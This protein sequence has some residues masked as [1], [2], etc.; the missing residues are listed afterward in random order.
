MP[1]GRRAALPPSRRRNRVWF[2]LL[3]VVCICG[4]G[5]ALVLP[6]VLLPMFVQSRYPARKV[7][8]LSNIRQTAAAQLLY[9][10]EFDETL[11][12][13]KTWVTASIPYASSTSVYQCP[14]VSSSSFGFA[15]SAWFGGAKLRKIHSHDE[16]L[17]LFEP[18]VAGIN[19]SGYA[20]KDSANPPRHS[21]TNN[22]AFMDGHAKAVKP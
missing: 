1:R 4:C 3:S 5:G 21:G 8:C 2:V 20:S 18:M 16:T 22:V 9:A 17:L 7:D 13:L 6:A 10:A 14:A 19:A 15:M 12:P 11:P